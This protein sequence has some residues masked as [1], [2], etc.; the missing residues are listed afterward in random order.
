MVS[1]KTNFITIVYYVL[2]R[3]QINVSCFRDSF[4]SCYSEIKMS[5]C[6]MQVIIMYKRI[7]T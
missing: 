7:D 2:F 3:R 4:D 1:D 6:R 5:D